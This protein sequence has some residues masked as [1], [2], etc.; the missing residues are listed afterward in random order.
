[1]YQ[2]STGS[3]RIILQHPT[4]EQLQRHFFHAAVP[5]IGFG[6]MDQTALI[7]AGNA[8]D[9]TLGVTLGLSTMAVAALRQIVSGAAAAIFGSTLNT[10]FRTWTVPSGLTDAQRSLGCVKRVGSL[11]SLVGVVTGC[12]LGLV[13][14]LFIDTDE[15][16]MRKLEAYNEGMDQ[17]QLYRIETVSNTDTQ[18]TFTYTVQ[19]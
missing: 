7:Q 19:T 16:P 15:A 6:F 5:M 8:I 13:N 18:T 9:C 14:L 1:M 17:Q 2:H 10:M 12:V 11:G 4:R 3:S